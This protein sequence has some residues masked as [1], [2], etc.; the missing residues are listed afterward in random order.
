MPNCGRGV[1]LWSAL[2]LTAVSA[3]APALAPAL[4][5]TADPETPRA[6][7]RQA[8]H[9]VAVDSAR[10]LVTRWQQRLSADPGDRRAALGVATVVLFSGS[11]PAADS[12]FRALLA[13]PD[14]PVAEYAALEHGVAL[15][16][17]GRWTAAVQALDSAA[18]RARV[19]SD[20][21]GEAEALLT[22]VPIENR[23]R[24]PAVASDLAR[25][26]AITPATARGLRARSVCVHAILLAPT[27]AGAALDSARA[28]AAAAR[29]ADDLRVAADCEFVTAVNLADRGRSDSAIVAFG[30]VIRHATATGD[31]VLRAT[32]LQWR[33]YVAMT[34][35]RY[36]PAEA[37]LI[38][39]VTEGHRVGD[40]AAI[41]W[42]EL[43]LS[44]A[45]WY[46]G[47]IPSARRWAARSR[48]VL[49]ANGDA[50]GLG[51]LRRG[52]GRVALSSGDTAAARADYL[53]A[54]RG[55]ERLGHA[56]DMAAA[57]VELSDLD[58]RAGHFEVAATELDTAWR[59]SSAAH[60]SWAQVFPWHHGRLAL[61]RGQLRQA[62]SDFDAVARTNDS[63]QHLFRYQM[64]EG[65]ASA[66]LGLGDTT[67]AI[68][69][70]TRANLAFDQWRA[71][72]TDE[73]LRVLAFQVA[74][75]YECPIQGPAAIIAA[76]ARSGRVPTAFALAERRRARELDDQL[77]RAEA[78]R[79]V[80]AG[81]T[82][83]AMHG[84]A[85][86]GVVSLQ[87]LQQAIPDDSTAVLE[88]V[89]GPAR[90]PTTLFVV[91]RRTTRATLLPSIDSL[92]DAIDRLDAL[93]EQ[94]APIDAPA[95]ELGGALLGRATG[96]LPGA[97]P[98]RVTRLV[99]VPDGPLYR[100]PFA[101]LR[102][103]SGRAVVERYAIA[104]APS[105]T[106]IATLWHRPRRVGIARVLA[107]GD[108]ILPHEA[109]AETISED[110]PTA[111]AT[112][113]ARGTPDTTAVGLIADT[114]VSADRDAAAALDRAGELP[115]VP[116]SADEAAL[117]G[118]FGTG[119][120]VRLRADASAAYLARARLDS[121]AVVHFATHAV[122]D[123]ASPA[124]SALALAPG[125]GYTGFV[126]PGDLELLRLHADLVV[127][128]ACRTARGAIV[129]GEGVR[130]FAAP[131]L[132]A[133]ARG[134]LVTQWS[135]NDRGAVP[136]V[137]AIYRG[138]A[139]NLPIAE[140][141]RRAELA[142]L[143]RGAPVRAWAAFTVTGDPLVRIA[144]HAPAR[145]HVPAWLRDSP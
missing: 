98:R 64:R 6:V 145:D 29:G 115:R 21:M 52:D 57:Y 81:A 78:L 79:A 95:R 45:A 8:M 66:W 110:D 139:A 102:L 103:P 121:F 14:D 94:N 75:P 99:I 128:S 48:A 18:T 42:A 65:E 91:T 97:L 23:W 58:S 36:G 133:G 109:I 61:C 135:L 11:L 132:A 49:T 130:G 92:T 50:F 55:A 73:A 126:D 59:L 71:S 131:L 10:D 86:A 9:A 72:L 26:D 134:V 104:I 125:G 116:W 144:L 80:D 41:G 63:A 84:A 93:V 129:A 113:V 62:V 76:A 34:L 43:N 141:V 35:G 44:V 142:A 37:D 51:V 31:H 56:V 22:A 89:V 70:L 7:V 47:D 111:A 19:R 20:S 136:I 83:V 60:T 39:A 54:L 112:G 30:V 100:V 3:L 90:A 137:Y 138:I 106:V 107:F 67:R 40:L 120:V 28:G 127:L 27:D 4:A 117:V 119:S 87:R 24:S 5:Q 105:A 68:A 13:P 2:S 17:I 96:A 38:D 69:V 85:D 15:A 123:E 32:A 82:S 124:R 122:I 1:A 46:T 33:G 12:V 25:A 77:R 74:S 88:Y 118:S 114:A 143:E 101:A 140:A 53:E 16:R 108:P